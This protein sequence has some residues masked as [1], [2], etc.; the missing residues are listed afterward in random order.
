MRRKSL[1][2]RQDDEP[3]RRQAEAWRKRPR[4]KD[5]SCQECL[6]RSNFLSNQSMWLVVY[7]SADHFL[8]VPN[9]AMGAVK[10]V[11]GSD[12]TR[13]GRMGLQHL[14]EPNQRQ[15]PSRDTAVL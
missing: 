10:W 13:I 14:R 11:E 7:A 9:K 12:L 6:E 15:E 3:G 4:G 5:E 8:D 2:S 1:H